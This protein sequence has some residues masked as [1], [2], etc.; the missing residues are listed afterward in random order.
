MMNKTAI[1]IIN[2]LLF[3]FLNIQFKPG[4]LPPVKNVVCSQAAIKFSKSNT[5]ARTTER[6]LPI[7]DN[8]LPGVMGD[9]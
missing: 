8:G 7:E 4:F 5:F 9:G 2:L 3:F 6:D 1:I